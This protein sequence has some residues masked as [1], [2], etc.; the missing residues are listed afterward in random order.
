MYCDTDESSIDEIMTPKESSAEERSPQRNV[1]MVKKVTL[2]TIIKLFLVMMIFTFGTM[3]TYAIIATALKEPITLI[4][5]G[6]M[7]LVVASIYIKN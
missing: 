5:L 3:A 7:G 4:G 1:L 6:L 2:Y